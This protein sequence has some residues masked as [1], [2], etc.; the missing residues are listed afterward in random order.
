MATHP[1]PIKSFLGY[2]KDL[3]LHLSR[4]ELQGIRREICGHR[5]P[6]DAVDFES[7]GAEGTIAAMLGPVLSRIQ[8]VPQHEEVLEPFVPRM[9]P[10]AS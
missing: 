9:I 8:S 2:G 5:L 10:L 1:K 6:P 4:E 3:G 7:G